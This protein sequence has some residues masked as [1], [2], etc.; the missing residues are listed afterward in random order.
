MFDVYSAQPVLSG[1]LA[2]PQ[3][4]PLNTGLTVLTNTHLE[5]EEG[6]E[7]RIFRSCTQGTTKAKWLTS[8][9][10]L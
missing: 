10:E 9:G 7:Q 5:G 2:I 1:Y 8:T 6:Q 3:G 4:R